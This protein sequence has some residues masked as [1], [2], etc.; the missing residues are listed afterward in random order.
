[1]TLSG[2][3]PNRFDGPI[4]GANNYLRTLLLNEPVVRDLIVRLGDLQTE[5]RSSPNYGKLRETSLDGE[6]FLVDAAFPER[7][8]YEGA[9][10]ASP[11]REFFSAGQLDHLATVARERI[12]TGLWGKS[13]P[14][15]DMGA[16]YGRE[17]Q[18]AR[19]M[20]TGSIELAVVDFVA[21]LSPPKPEPKPP[22]GVDPIWFSCPHC[23]AV[24]GEPCDAGKMHAARFAA[25][26]AS[27]ERRAKK[28][29]RARVRKARQRIRELPKL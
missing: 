14:V 6:P 3:T 25:A 16:G 4:E 7:R 20:T 28:A 9:R 1:V 8:R 29:E 10:E 11:L 12:E 19:A 17:K 22:P 26:R 21:R 27:I 5:W 18:R 2:I 15:N 23:D 13:I 24:P